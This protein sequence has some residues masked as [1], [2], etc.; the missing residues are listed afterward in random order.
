MIVKIYNLKRDKNR[1]IGYMKVSDSHFTRIIEGDKTKVVPNEFFYRK[2]KRILKLKWNN[3]DFAWK[4]L[5]ENEVTEIIENYKRKESFY[6]KQRNIL[7]TLQT[8]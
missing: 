7:E 5:S 8:L 6:L 3:D 2:F 1:L 4:E